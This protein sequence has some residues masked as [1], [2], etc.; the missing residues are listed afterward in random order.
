MFGV[1]FRPSIIPLLYFYSLSLSLWRHWWL[2][3]QKFGKVTYII[4]L[5][6]AVMISSTNHTTLLLQK[7]KTP[8]KEF[9]KSYWGTW[10]SCWW[11]WWCHL[12]LPALIC[13]ILGKVSNQWKNTVNLSF[14]LV[15]LTQF[16]KL[17]FLVGLGMITNHC[18]SVPGSGLGPGLVAGNQTCRT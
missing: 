10:S 5:D 15:S 18:W 8:S 3:L 2:Y 4:N 12:K 16:F 17:F 11:W 14:P 6:F 13:C 9:C 7:T 1:W